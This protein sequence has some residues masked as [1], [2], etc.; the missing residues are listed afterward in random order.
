MTAR[1]IARTIACSWAEVF[2]SALRDLRCMVFVTIYTVS[3][4]AIKPLLAALRL[5]E[6]FFSTNA[7]A[8]ADTERYSVGSSY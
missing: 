4:Q 7:Y 8:P 2:T 6:R 1:T 3:V 5:G